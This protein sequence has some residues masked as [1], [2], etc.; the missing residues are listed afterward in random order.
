MK[1]PMQHQELKDNV[2]R[3][4]ENKLITWLVDQLPDGMNSLAWEFCKEGYDAADYDQI[5]Q[6][7]GYSVSGIPYK[8]RDLFAVTDNQIQPNEAY[9]Q[10]YKKLKKALAPIVEEVYDIHVEAESN[11]T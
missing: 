6:Q 1:H 11:Q 9:E 4:V 3:F 7:I 10:A 2:Q 5:L 8:N